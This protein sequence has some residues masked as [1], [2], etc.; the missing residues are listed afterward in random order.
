MLTEREELILKAIV[1]EYINTGEPIS[2]KVVA[3]KYCPFV[4]SATVRNDMGILEEMG[5]ITQPHPSAGR[6]PSP[7]GYKYYIENLLLDCKLPSPQ[8]MRIRKILSNLESEVRDI[9]EIIKT[10][11][12]LIAQLS[13]LLAFSYGPISS[14]RFIKKLWLTPIDDNNVL[15]IYMTET[16]DVE[17]RIIHARY[18]PL[19][20]ERLSNIFSTKLEKES[21]DKLDIREILALLPEEESLI[22]EIFNSL[23]REY[24][25]AESYIE[26]TDYI[27]KIP[28]FN[29]P[30]I[31]KSLINIINKE[32]LV[33]EQINAAISSG[34]VWTSIG[35]RGN[36]TFIVVPYFAKNLPIGA[37][38]VVGPI[39]MNYKYIIPLLS[40]IKNCIS[41]MLSVRWR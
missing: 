1:E 6:V 23:K 34:D 33:I 24:S 9:R 26:G 10:T 37:A 36:L 15:L 31:L 22:K 5:Y 32:E 20:L 28:E 35:E 7:K 16:G 40:Y 14:G 21:I 27:D 4:S 19:N 38:G 30:E 25:Y 17:H 3:S 18:N 39:R 8:R 41:D 12:W 29:D 2:S 11:S 13:K